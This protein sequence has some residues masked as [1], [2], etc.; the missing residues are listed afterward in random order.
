MCSFNYTSD[1]QKRLGYVNPTLINQLTLNPQLNENSETY[2]AR[3]KKKKDTTQKTNKREKGYCINPLRSNHDAV[4]RQRL[5][6]G[7]HITSC[8]FLLSYDQLYLINQNN[9]M[10]MS[11]YSHHWILALIH[12]KISGIFILDPLDVNESTYKEFINCIK[13]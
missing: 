4:T 6:L 13:K 11:L 10:H 7:P 12:P 2:K 9:N 3:G 8:K 1:P 5:Y